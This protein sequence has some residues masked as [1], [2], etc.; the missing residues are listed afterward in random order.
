MGK[1]ESDPVWVEIVLM[2]D[3]EGILTDRMDVE[4]TEDGDGGDGR[5]R[6]RLRM[7]EGDREGRIGSR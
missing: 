1:D 5:I 2:E 4:W 7:K 6:G 3:R